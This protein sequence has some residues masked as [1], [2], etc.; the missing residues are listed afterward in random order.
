ML[1][2]FILFLKNE[3]IGIYDNEEI[4]NNFI[5]GCLQNNFFN[6]DDIKIKKYNINSINCL[7][8]DNTNYQNKI[9]SE[10]K[11]IIKE[12]KIENIK[13]NVI[14]SEEYI[15]LMQT[16]I[17]TKHQINELKK[18]K[19]KLEEEKESY[20]YDLKIYKKLK[21]EK[22]KIENFE[23]PEIFTLKFNIYK[24][25]EETNQL[26]FE[27]FKIEWEKV[28]PQNNYSLFSPNIYENSFINSNNKE[29]INIDIDI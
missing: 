7:N 17:D 10:K 15:K 21:N 14:E 23:I 20:E 13:K 19:I 2:G 16:K 22:E 18:Q 27:V 24:K 5:N 28:K 29:D 25:L 3:A 26:N 4:L 8:I 6:K 1:V 12:K 9:I 11:E